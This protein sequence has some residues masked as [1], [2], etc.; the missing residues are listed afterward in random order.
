M[1]QVNLNDAVE[2]FLEYCT[3]VKGFSGNTIHAY[4]N[5]LNRFKQKIHN[6]NVDSIALS[7]ISKFLDSKEEKVRAASTRARTIATLRSFFLFCENEYE[8]NVVDIKEL[9]LPKVPM[10]PAKALTQEEVSDILRVFSDDIIG[11]RDR[12]LCEILYATGIRISEAQGL[13]TSDIDYENKVLRVLGK[14]SKERV[15]PIG[16]VAI[17]ALKEYHHNARSQILQKAKVA[18]STNALFL[19]Q[20][21]KRLSRQGLYDIVLTAAK[22]VGL[23]KKVSPHVFRHSCATHL[24]HNGADMRIVQEILG[25]ASLSTTQRYTAVDLDRLIYLYNRSHPR[26]KTRAKAK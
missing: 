26:A 7:D 25:H 22:K 6:K 16:S 19:S 4:T 17:E 21:G 24:L 11:K 5:D 9:S 10:T 23:E 8:L 1:S 3:S 20:R 13:D 18:A 12:A 14:G 2:E 15:V